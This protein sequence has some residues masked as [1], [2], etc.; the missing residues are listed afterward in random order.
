MTNN[1]QNNIFDQD[2][3]FF[4][5]LS[6]PDLGLLSRFRKF[7]FHPLFFSCYVICPTFF[8]LPNELRK[9]QKEIGDGELVWL[10]EVGVSVGRKK[11]QD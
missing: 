4:S 6:F 8:E 5:T 1:N 2:F 11:S 10:E 3:Q 9:V 7:E